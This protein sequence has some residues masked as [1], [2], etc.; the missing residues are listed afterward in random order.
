MAKGVARV[1]K[2]KTL[3]WVKVLHFSIERRA[4]S[5]VEGKGK[6]ESSFLSEWG[7]ANSRP[8][9]SSAQ[10]HLR[11]EFCFDLLHR[12]TESQAASGNRT[13]NLHRGSGE[14]RETSGRLHN[15]NQPC[16]VWQDQNANLIR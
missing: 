2:E 11:E 7:E 12:Q 10:R 3:I 15:S 9:T 6:L 8:H 4:R 1:F 14:P 5:G 16:S 13:P